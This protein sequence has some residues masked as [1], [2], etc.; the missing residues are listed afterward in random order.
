MYKMQNNVTKQLSA[1]LKHGE[2]KYIKWVYK[3]MFVF[4]VTVTTEIVQYYK[5]LVLRFSHLNRV[6]ASPYMLIRC[7]SEQRDIL[8]RK[9]IYAM[10][11][12]ITF[13]KHSRNSLIT[14][15]SQDVRSLEICQFHEVEIQAHNL[16]TKNSRI[17]KAA[18]IKCKKKKM[19]RHD[20]SKG[21]S[22]GGSNSWQGW[23]M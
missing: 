9:H 3:C 8:L 2:S 11:P 15:K 5:I 20:A 1:W 6:V 4:Y 19:R 13:E 23:N 12:P 21:V 16:T 7:S 10:W 22:R 14:W 17:L 18:R